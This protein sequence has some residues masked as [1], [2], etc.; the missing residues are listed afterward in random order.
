MKRETDYAYDITEEQIRAY[1]HLSAI[2]RLRWLDQARRFTL[3]ARRAETIGPGG[4]VES[5]PN[6]KPQPGR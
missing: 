1:L 5:R 3:L 2:D 4:E 6:T